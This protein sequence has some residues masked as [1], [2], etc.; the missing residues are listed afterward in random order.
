VNTGVKM[1]LIEL[2]RL[3]KEGAI[4]LLVL[5]AIMIYIL[6][7]NGDPVIPSGFLEAFLVLYASF[8]GWSM[9]DR[10]G[11]DNAL[12]YLLSMPVSRSRL[13]MLKFLPRF[14]FVALVLGI[15]M[16]LHQV[17]NF[18]SFL[19]QVQFSIIYIAFFL[20]S[21][22]FSL[23]IRSYIGALFMT[24][25][26]SIG[27]VLFIKMTD[28][29]ISDTHTI[30]IANL[31]LISFPITF[32][33]AFRTF[34]IRPI[35]IFNKKLL[36]P[37][38][39]I[40][41]LVTGF[42]WLRHHPTWWGYYLTKEG[43]IVRASC[44]MQRG[45]FLQHGNSI[46][47]LPLGGSAW[48]LVE[49]E[50][51]L[52]IQVRKISENHCYTKSIKMIDLKK[53]SVNSLWHLPD[54]WVIYHNLLGANGRII[55]DHYYNLISNWEEKQYKIIIL[56]LTD[57][58]HTPK[59]IQLSGSIE[60][61]IRYMF[62]IS[63][64]PMRFFFGSKNDLYWAKE[65]GQLHLFHQSPQSMTAWKNSVLVFD[66]D[67]MT[68]YECGDEMKPVLMK[69]G[70]IRKIRPRHGG[71]TGRKVLV[72]VGMDLRIF[73]M[74]IRR[75]QPT[76]LESAPRYYHFSGDDAQTMHLLWIKMDKLTYGTLE[77]GQLTIQKKGTVHV[78]GSYN[79]RVTQ[80]GAVFY[81]ENE[82]QVFKFNK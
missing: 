45:Q 41:V 59:E 68:L 64:E 53:G 56:P 61:P 79:I 46:D 12:E 24:A 37:L 57:S 50:N 9:F 25:F 67:K 10:E 58:R 8:T 31:I 27:L 80:S 7:G 78:E 5:T 47:P 28:A 17:F 43:D 55:K 63:Q 35:G 39:V 14:L 48:P 74:E 69:E 2:K 70:I 42:F 81:N 21:L 30:L 82:F 15:Y 73:D 13:F 6:T 33:L 18:P 38:L 19:P 52:L 3:L 66:N 44:S 29:D 1:A 34:D 75:F 22:S 65:D 11:Q 36:P 71:F 49:R 20:V 77:N 62:H 60:E 32:Y 4:L 26:F 72:R 23:T 51:Q 54:Q 40:M 16:L 76:P